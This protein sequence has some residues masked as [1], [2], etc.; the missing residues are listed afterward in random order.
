MMSAFLFSLSVVLTG[1]AAAFLSS[2][3]AN[4]LA[5]C[6]CGVQG[7]FFSIFFVGIKCK[8]FHFLVRLERHS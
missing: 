5:P 3:A 1:V 8:D 6:F 4:R 2:S 7:R